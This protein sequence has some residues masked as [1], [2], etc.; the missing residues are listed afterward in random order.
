MS[1]RRPLYKIW[2]SGK[3]L[4]YRNK[5]KLIKD[6]YKNR[7]QIAAKKEVNSPW[8]SKRI[9]VEIWFSQNSAV[10][11]DVDNV[12]KLV[13]DALQG[14]VYV[15]DSQV[16]SVKVGCIPRDDAF[17]IEKEESDDFFRLLDN[18][19]EEFLI[20]IFYG[21]S[22]GGKNTSNIICYP[23]KSLKKNNI[24]AKTKLIKNWTYKTDIRT[25]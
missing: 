20:R 19:K 21:M 14:I 3:P 23:I 10:R 11:P 2:I 18:K 4:N 1:T 5:S 6:D 22:I 16:R 13:L 12:T 15:N 7:I 17:E 24:I 25:Q 9:D 8:R